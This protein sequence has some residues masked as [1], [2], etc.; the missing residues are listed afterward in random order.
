MPRVAWQVDPFGH[1]REEASLF[2]QMGMD[3]M[4]FWRIDE[5]DRIQ[6][7]EEQ[8]LEVITTIGF[9]FY[10]SLQTIILILDYLGRHGSFRGRNFDLHG[11]HS[12]LLQPRRLLLRQSLQ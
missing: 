5:R 8:F 12:R 6:R 11:C 9:P 4:Y 1:S 7:K 3:S 2:A 10:F